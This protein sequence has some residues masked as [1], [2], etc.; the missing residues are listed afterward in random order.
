M[1]G[2]LLLMAAIL[3]PLAGGMAVW[4]FRRRLTY[5]CRINLAISATVLLLVLVTWFAGGRGVTV[6]LPNFLFVGLSFR[7]DMLSLFFAV[8]F[9][10][11]WT[12]ASIYSIGYMI[13]EC[14]HARFYFFLLLTF[15]GCMGVVLAADLFTLFLFFELMTFS[16]YVLVIHK[17]NDDAMNAGFLYLFL[18]V[19]GG[20]ALLLGIILLHNLTGSAGFVPLSAEHLENTGRI[21]VIAVC[22]LLGF[23]IKAGIVPLHI[24]LP[25][26][27]P[28]APTPASALLSGIMIKTGAYGL[29]RVFYMVLFPLGRELV[30]SQVF[31][32]LFLWLGLFTMLVG[33]FLALQQTQAKVTLAYS[34]VSQIGYIVLGLGAAMLP[35]GK[36][37]YGV[38]GLLFHILNH[39][40]FKATLFMTVGAIYIYT[41]TLDYNKL[42][43]LLRRF[44]VAT[45]AFVVSALGIMG[46][47]GFNGYASKTFLHHALTDLYAANPTWLLW[48]AEKLFVLASALTICYFVKMFVNIFLGQR[49]WASLPARMSN[50]LNVPLLIGVV[51]VVAI[52]LLPGPVVSRIFSPALL[53][54]GLG[55]DAA[56]YASGVSVWIWPDIWA[57]VVTAA[58]AGVIYLLVG[59]FSLDKLKFPK[60]LSVERLIYLPI[61]RG[62]LLFCLGPGVLLDRKINQIYHGTGDFSMDLCRFVGK[63]DRSIDKIYGQAGGFSLQVCK[64]AGMLDRGLDRAYNKIGGTSMKVAINLGELDSELDGIYN[65][66]GL[67]SARAV[68]KLSAMEDHLSGKNVTRPSEVKPNGLFG[69][70]QKLLDN[71]KWNISNLNV[72]AILVAV[73]LVVVVI[74]FV[75]Y[76]RR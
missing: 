69:Q 29:F 39:A 57:M 49:K 1:P 68:H 33:A 22:F 20:L 40:V 43:G 44:P 47:P 13:N 64:A 27:H 41:H 30:T 54:V 73:A 2:Q 56:A 58:V 50:W 10:G 67:S 35:I 21:A 4:L 16:S 42:G 3:L 48:L 76:G 7:L 19:I 74:I 31:G 25:K 26:A 9:A 60:W 24:W 53:A 5:I 70:L 34:S 32:W 66:L 45:A 28:V 72:E 36:D 17:E 52:G 65:K 61:A 6:E 71:P 75:F 63:V 14:S 38:T 62:F 23:G 8:L 15:A 55:A 12:T 46:M 37:L 18:G 51:A 59:R 11:T